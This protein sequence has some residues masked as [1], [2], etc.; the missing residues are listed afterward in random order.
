MCSL[1]TGVQTCTLPICRAILLDKGRKIADGPTKDVT[2][3][4]YAL[5]EAEERKA[6]DSRVDRN[7]RGRV[8]FTDIWNDNAEG[9]RAIGRASSRGRQGQVGT[10]SGVDVVFKTTYK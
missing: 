7:G 5:F 3:E 10:N 6:L 9:Q 8:R 4:Y 1:V 2:G